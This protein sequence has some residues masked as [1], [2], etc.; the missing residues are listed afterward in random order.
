MSK[1]THEVGITIQR[2]LGNM[3]LRMLGAR[4]L[5]TT[6]NKLGGL[7]FKIGKN[8]NRV[9]HIGITLDASDTYDVTF[10]R[11]KRAGSKGPLVEVVAFYDGVYVDML[12][13][14]IESN[15]GLYT[16]LVAS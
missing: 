6:D 16:T 5:V 10:S 7:Q 15:T 12:R 1:E 4:N 11:V 3:T 9:T 14:I 8:S 13:D 2:Q